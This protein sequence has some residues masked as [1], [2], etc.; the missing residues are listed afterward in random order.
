MN[1]SY[2]LT[3]TRNYVA[4]WGLGE[5]V[6]E[7]IQN[8]LDS[9][10]PFA[11]E[12]D[13]SGDGSLVLSL[14]S[15]GVTLPPKMLL[16]GSTGKAG[17]EDMIG[18]FGEGFKIALLVLTRLGHGV[19][20]RNGPVI[21]TPRFRKSE[22]FGEEVLTIYETPATG[23]LFREDLI[24]EVYGLTKDDADEIVRSCLLM[25]ATK[26]E[27]IETEKGEILLERPGSLYVGNLYVCKITMAYGYNVKPK[28]LR[29]D[30]DRQTVSSYDL[31]Q[32]TLDMWNA[33]ERWDHIADMIDR[34][35]Q[36]V[37]YAQF[38]VP[39]PVQKACYELFQKRNPNSLIANSQK[40]LE[41][42]EKSVDR[43]VIRVGAGMY[44]AISAYAPYRSSYTVRPQATPTER[45]VEFRDEH[46]TPFVAMD[47]RTKFDALI[48]ESK[49]WV[50]K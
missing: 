23:K 30:R 17:N 38:G 22:T 32:L 33:T 42:L 25:Q 47:T 43:R 35:V 16:L 31:Y 27:T 1:K 9:E 4:R 10:R 37:Y 7:L 14:H 21:W 50:L 13:D 46:M 6:R 8:A 28:Y 29:L 18:A 5:A 41:Q 48:E 15:A 40:E 3:L 44:G 12:F 11:Y 24:F 34:E 20:I 19:V 45:L 39:E 26:G 2:E 36:D 49:N